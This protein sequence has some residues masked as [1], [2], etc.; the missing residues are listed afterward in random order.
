MVYNEIKSGDIP[1]LSFLMEPY[2]TIQ[3]IDEE[4]DL[5]KEGSRK[6]H[7]TLPPWWRRGIIAISFDESE[8]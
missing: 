3:I 8:L 5:Y 1:D 6:Y 7:V 4:S 2:T